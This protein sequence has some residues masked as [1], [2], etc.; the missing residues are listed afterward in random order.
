MGSIYPCFE[1]ARWDRLGY[2]T[3]DF[4]QCTRFVSVHH[5]VRSTTN[6]RKFRVLANGRKRCTVFAETITDAKK[7]ACEKCGWDVADI[8][9]V[10]MLHH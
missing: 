1:G 4:E 5:G 6:R 7:Q 10:H 9:D 2:D 8:Y 3:Y